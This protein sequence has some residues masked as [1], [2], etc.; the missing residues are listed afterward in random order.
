MCRLL[1]PWNPE[2]PP[3]STATLRCCFS[4]SLASMSLSLL[5]H[6]SDRM[7]TGEAAGAG[8]AEEV[9]LGKSLERFEGRAEV[10]R[11]LREADESK[12]EDRV[13]AISEGNEMSGQSVRNN[14]WIKQVI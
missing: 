3:P 13:E 5:T 10:R 6:V 11:S 7:T 14:F 2:H 8:E 1:L 4:P 12:S 9:H